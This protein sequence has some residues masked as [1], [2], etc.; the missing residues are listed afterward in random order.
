MIQRLAIFLLFFAFAFNSTAQDLSRSATV[1]ILTVEPGHEELFAA[2]GHSAIRIQDPENQID[3]VYNFGTYYY[4]QPYFYVNFARGYLL[5]GL[6]VSNWQRFQ[7][8]YAYFNRQVIAQYLNLS[9]DQTQQVFDF[10]ENNAKP[11]NSKYYYDYFYDNCATRIRDVFVQVLGDDIKLPQNYS[12]NPNQTVRQLTDF[13]IEEEF[14]WGKLGIDLCLG[15]PMD[16]QLSDY[17]YM[18]LP[19]YIFDAFEKAQIQ[20]NNT[21]LP[22]VKEKQV[23]LQSR[24]ME[25]P[26]PWFTPTIA[27]GLCALLGIIFLILQYKKGWLFRWFDFIWFFGVGLIGLLLL[28]LWVATDHNAAA[29]NFNILW[30]LPTHLIVA[31][32]LVRKKVKRWVNWYL[33]LL[34]PYSIIMLLFWKTFPQDLNEGFIP[35][36]L[37]MIVRSVAIILRK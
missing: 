3:K 30:A 4:N 23:I 33:L 9:E 24:E 32:A 15:L 16:K 25:Y 26:K 37:L 22:S 1:S 27:F 8:Y 2:F 6:S 12:N 29:N 10:L 5:Y 11:E 13:Y 14:P 31:F 28:L 7:G 35:I 19:D 21:W 17:E 20:H 18:Y 36:V 34:M